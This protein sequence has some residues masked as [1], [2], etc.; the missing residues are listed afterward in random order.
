[1]ENDRKKQE[2]LKVN[3]GSNPKG[4]QGRVRKKRP[5]HKKRKLK[6][7]NNFRIKRYF[8]KKKKRIGSRG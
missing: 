4:R 7:D 5:Q 6:L 3:N 1:M 2:P 8:G